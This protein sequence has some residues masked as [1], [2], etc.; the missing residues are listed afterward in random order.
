MIP[1]LWG[2]LICGFIA[3]SKIVVFGPKESGK[4]TI[5]EKLCQQPQ[6]QRYHEYEL[7]ANLSIVE[8]EGYDAVSSQVLAVQIQDAGL[9]MESV[10]L[11]LML[12]DPLIEY[13]RILSTQQALSRLLPV[14]TSKILGL[15]TKSDVDEFAATDDRVRIFRQRGIKSIVVGSNTNREEI[16]E[17]IGPFFNVETARPLSLPVLNTPFDQLI[18]ALSGWT[19]EQIRSTS[20]SVSNSAFN[21]DGDDVSFTLYRR[22]QETVLVNPSSKLMARI[23]SDGLE[24]RQELPFD[25]SISSDVQVLLSGDFG[26]ISSNAPLA[27]FGRSK[28]DRISSSRIAVSEKSS[29]HVKDLECQGK[30]CS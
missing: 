29:I 5:V 4:T 2:L 12:E 26:K 28:V 19:Q 16:L 6:T 17:A 25:L 13:S 21:F 15:V 24:I 22:E 14:P 9:C 1:A 8:V 10:G 11:V 30:H 7:R 20:I 18:S 23:G 27:I 3:A